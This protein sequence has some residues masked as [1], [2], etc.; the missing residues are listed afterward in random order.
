MPYRPHSEYRSPYDLPQRD[1]KRRP[2]VAWFVVG[3]V[4]MVAAAV[5]F[6]VGVVGFAR[7]ITH[8][9]AVFRAAGSHAVSLPPGT[10]RA[11]FVPEGRPIPLCQVTDGT[12]TPLHFR[13][14]DQRF[15]YNTWVAVRA[16]DTGD[17]NIV[18]TCPPGVGGRIRI[19]EMPTGG[20]VA[21]FGVVGVLLPLALGGVGFVMVLVTGILFYTRRPQ[22][23]AYGAAYGGVYG[24]PG[25]PPYG[26]APGYPLAP[27]TGGE[28]GPGPGTQPDASS[29]A[30]PPDP[31]DGSPPAPG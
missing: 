31:S 18:F 16:F 24:A 20:D 6:G 25:G 1:R 17:G 13:R 2:S 11:M 29:E 23:P 14:P 26:A 27:P 5:V 28:P 12:G 15:T 4:L 10:E 8:T 22:Q 9:D 7:T 21:R 30:P 3:G 19:A